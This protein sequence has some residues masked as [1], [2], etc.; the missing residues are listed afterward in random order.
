MT[1]MCE[2]GSRMLAAASSTVTLARSMGASCGTAVVG[3]VM[4]VLIGASVTAN[5]NTP[6]YQMQGLVAHAFIGVFL[7]IGGFA[8]FASILAWSVPRRTL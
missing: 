7:V 4:S 3:V 6:A 2:A 8:A 5:A 1:M